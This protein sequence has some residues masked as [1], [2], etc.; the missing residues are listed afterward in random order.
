MYTRRNGVDFID[1]IPCQIVVT[2]R[3]DAEEGFDEAYEWEVRDRKGYPAPW[4]ERK[5]TPM[6]E[7]LIY[8]EILRQKK[9]SEAEYWESQYDY[10]KGYY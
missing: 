2:G 5:L 7:H 3:L 10:Y 6:D 1:R 8:D 4:L 9:E